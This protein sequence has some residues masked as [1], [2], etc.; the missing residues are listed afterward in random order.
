VLT[1]ATPPPLERT[2]SGK[3]FEFEPNWMGLQALTL[4]F[5]QTITAK[6]TFG[7]G[8]KQSQWGAS[9]RVKGKARGK[10][11]FTETR[12][13]SRN[14]AVVLSPNGILGAPVGL[15]AHWEDGKVFLLEYDEVSSIN[16]YWLRVS[17]TESG[18][19]VAA[20]E[21]TGLFDETFA[22]KMK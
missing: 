3:T 18:V 19:S 22:G 14:G 9:S 8:V 17:F 21:R 1:L 11:A 5:D 2:L 16:G 6:L 12:S 15:R 4:T 20:K 10:A 13:V 7:Y